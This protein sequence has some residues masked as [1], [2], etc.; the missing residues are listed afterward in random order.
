MGGAGDGDGWGGEGTAATRASRPGNSPSITGT[1]MNLA[2]DGLP[3]QL[4]QPHPLAETDTRRGSAGPNPPQS[5][6]IKDQLIF[7]LKHR[8]KN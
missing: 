4:G 7:T 2:R 1:L 5:G 8:G 6:L 3:S